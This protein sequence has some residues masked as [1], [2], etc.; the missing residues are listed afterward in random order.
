MCPHFKKF[1][2][3]LT[4]DDGLMSPISLRPK[5]D[6]MDG[7]VE[8]FGSFS[9]RSKSLKSCSMPMLA[10]PSLSSSLLLLLLLPKL[11]DGISD[12]PKL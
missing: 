3:H 11:S 7:A 8:I 1:L 9:G 10:P 4:T 5:L 6:S 2:T 12:D